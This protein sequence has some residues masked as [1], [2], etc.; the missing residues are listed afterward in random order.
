MF[1][2]SVIFRFLGVLFKWI[3]SGFKGSFSEYWK[4]RNLNNEFEEIL[5]GVGI[6]IVLSQIL[7]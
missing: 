3:L 2:G 5:I 1:I 6:I 7:L 4:N